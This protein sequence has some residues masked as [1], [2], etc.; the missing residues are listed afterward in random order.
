MT[1]DWETASR[2]EG[3]TELMLN[4]FKRLRFSYECPASTYYISEIL[5]LHVDI[6]A[7]P[8]G[9][10]DSEP[11]SPSTK[12]INECSYV[13]MFEHSYMGALFAFEQSSFQK[14]EREIDNDAKRR[15]ILGEA[16]LEIYSMVSFQ[17]QIAHFIFYGFSKHEILLIIWF[18]SGVHVLRMISSVCGLCPL[19]PI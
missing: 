3:I 4:T 19:E 10:S 13:V 7:W 17:T 18:S 16:S 15:M 2:R 11:I 9:S 6:F 5:K 1:F 14:T 12:S 8:V